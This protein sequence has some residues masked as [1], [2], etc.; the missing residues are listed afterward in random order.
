MINLGCEL[1][2]LWQ[3][4][5]F[6]TEHVEEHSSRNELVTEQCRVHTAEGERMQRMA[7]GTCLEEA[8]AVMGPRCYLNAW[9]VLSVVSKSSSLG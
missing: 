5:E 2:Y 7:V 8:Q 1:H 9:P 6:A 4:G 3:V